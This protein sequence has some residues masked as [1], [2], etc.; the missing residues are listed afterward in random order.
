[1]KEYS[2]TKLFCRSNSIV[3]L[4]IVWPIP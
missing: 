4:S 2:V 1:M 3:K